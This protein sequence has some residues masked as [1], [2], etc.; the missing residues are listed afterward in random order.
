[1]NAVNRL[2]VALVVIAA[3]GVVACNTGFEPQYRVT[4]LRLLAIRSQ[5]QGSP[6]TAD[7]WPGDTIVL[8]ALVANP[9]ARSGLTVTWFGCFPRADESLLPCDDPSLLEDPRRLATARGVTPLGT[10]ESLSVL[11]D[12]AAV[13]TA[14][15]FVKQ[16]ALAVPAFRCQLYAELVVVAVAEAQGERSAALKHV[17]V[18][19]RPADLT[20]SPLAGLANPNLNPSVQD[21]VSAPRDRATCEGGAALGSG[22]FP[23][24][25]SVLCGVAGPGPVDT[26]PVCGPDG[27]QSVETE[28]LSWQ[29]YVSAGEFP[30]FSGLGNATGSDVEYTRPAGAFTLWVIL[31]DGRGGAGWKTYALP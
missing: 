14:L 26:F 19:P 18:A 27:P 12:P 23:P 31:R 1:M 25:K 20:D 6:S 3:L 10:G 17:R 2:L 4:D 24:G 29:W 22:P 8:D 7:P 28:D 15:E 21:A 13:T 30:E 11:I 5:V 16:I 9:L